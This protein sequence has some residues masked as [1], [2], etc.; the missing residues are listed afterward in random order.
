MNPSPELIPMLKQLRLSGILDSIE[1]RNR[2][3]LEEKFSYMDFLAMILQDEVVRR[4]QKR[5][6]LAL[7]RASFRSQKTLEEF[8]FTFIPGLNRTL[9]TDLASCRFID[10]KVCVL[11]VGPCGTGK[12]HLAQ[13]LGHAAIRAGHDVLFSTTDRLLTQL[14]AARATN[15]Y[16]RQF[17]RFVNIDLLIIDDFGLKPLKGIQDE[18][19]HDVISERYERKSTMITSNLDVSEWAEAFPNRILGA[20]TVDRLRHGAYKVVL[21]GQSYRTAPMQTSHSHS[22][23]SAGVTHNTP[24]DLLS[25]GRDSRVVDNPLKQSEPS[26]PILCPKVEKNYPQKEVKK[27]L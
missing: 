3:A 7:R 9:I 26:P 18:D 8:D 14:H 21:D 6:A 22:R 12:S 13:A 11:I 16:E 17:A 2:Q 1:H 19:F 25:M 10:E 20:A 15:N 27:T 23:P 24:A 5:F 4:S